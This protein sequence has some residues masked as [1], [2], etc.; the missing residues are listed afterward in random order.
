MPLLT[1]QYH[2]D[3][4]TFFQSMLKYYFC[5][6]AISNYIYPLLSRCWTNIVF[7]SLSLSL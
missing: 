3:D 6:L 2:Y 1:F 7:P 4:L 5:P